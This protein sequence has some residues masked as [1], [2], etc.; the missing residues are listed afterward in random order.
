M[1][2]WDFLQK[3]G[4]TTTPEKLQKAFDAILKKPSLPP[5]L[6]SK[7]VEGLPERA[8]VYLLIYNIFF[9]WGGPGEEC[10]IFSPDFGLPNSS[11]KKR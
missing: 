4:N 5:L 10:C 3:V 1:V 9:F 2:L 6:K 8:G 11:P 7:D